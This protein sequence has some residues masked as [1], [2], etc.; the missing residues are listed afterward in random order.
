MPKKVVL[1][2]SVHAEMLNIKDKD[3]SEFINLLKSLT[4]KIIT[5]ENKNLTNQQLQRVD[6]LVIGNPIDDY[7][8]N[9]EIKNIINFVRDGGRLLLISEY[10]GDYLQKTNLNDITGKNFGIYFQKNIVK[11]YNSNNQNCSSIISVQNFQKHQITKQLRELVIGGTC[12]LLLKKDSKPLLYLNESWT[13]I[14]NGS[15]EQWSKE[16]GN[17]KQIISACME[18]GRGKVVAIGDIDIFSNDSNTGLNC[19][20]NRKFVLN[21]ISWLLEPVKESDVMLWA[22]N[23]LGAIQIEV[24][25][26]NNKINNIIETM[27]ILEHRISTI[28]EIKDDAEFENKLVEKELSEF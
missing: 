6:I 14:Y 19:L 20:D 22:L 21:L 26:I 12:S 15:N 11:Q 2:D 13:E 17:M 23:Q 27:T 24:K 9:I 3:F 1:F 28:E 5:N 7:F 25:R 4:L 18:Y 10:G 16:N 8:S